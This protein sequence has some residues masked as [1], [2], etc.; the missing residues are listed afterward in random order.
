LTPCLQR[1]VERRSHSCCG[2]P[3]GT[4]GPA[5]FGTLR[6]RWLYVTE[7]LRPTRPNHHPLDGP[8]QPD[9]TTDQPGDCIFWFGALKFFPGLSPAQDLAGR[10]IKTLSFGLLQ[11]TVSLPIL[12]AW[13]VVI[14]LG[15][16][17]GWFIEKRG[18]GGAI[19]PIP[20]RGGIHG[21]P[22]VPRRG[23]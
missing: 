9:F 22:Y 14:G 6:G 20:F 15:L 10:T 4:K 18:R 5:R 7:K 8:Q 11:P 12:A 23:T 17:T 1:T 16:I 3:F 19:K 13:E 2:S 21:L